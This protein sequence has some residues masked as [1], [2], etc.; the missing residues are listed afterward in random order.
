MTS[1][2]KITELRGII[3]RILVPLIG[4][5]CVLL[6]LPYYNNVGDVLIWEGTKHFLK[7]HGIDCLY[8]SS[9]ESFK[10]LEIPPDV[11][12]LLQGGG[13]FGDLYKQEQR[14]RNH[15]ISMYSNHRIIILPQTVYYQ[16]DENIK[17]DSSLYA[18]HKN[19]YIC[20]RDKKSMDILRSYFS[21]NNILLVPDMAF[22]ANINPNMKY[23]KYNIKGLLLRRNDQE[24]V[25]IKTD[26]IIGL[27]LEERD[28]PTI[29]KSKYSFKMRIF[30]LL[31][32]N[33]KLVGLLLDKLADSLYKDEIVRIGVDFINSYSVV[34][35]T[36]LHGVILSIMMDKQVF[37]FDNKY[38]KNISF[39]ETWL[40]DV[41]S[42]HLLK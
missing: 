23:N 10:E 18:K 29:D 28:W 39:Y 34:Y 35:S 25:E 9:K 7:D 4:N 2:D 17:N 26:S 16:C 30:G 12:I 19:L 13:N 42:V 33:R 15:I 3:E 41:N 21:Q 32:R 24:T 40:S 8:C 1:V 11:T 38:G 20:A 27:P 14:F 36:R 22:A 6:G 31:F 5:K 37:V